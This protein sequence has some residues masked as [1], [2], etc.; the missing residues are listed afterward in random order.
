MSDLRDAFTARAIWRIAGRRG[1]KEEEAKTGRGW[2]KE[3][4]RIGRTSDL[5]VMTKKYKLQQL[6]FCYT[7]MIR[8]S[9]CKNSMHAIFSRWVSCNLLPKTPEQFAEAKFYRP[10]ASSTMAASE[11]SF[12]AFCNL[13]PCRN[14][15]SLSRTTSKPHC[16]FAG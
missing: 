8:S 7:V 6:Q 16:S 13:D 14:D 11:T 5:V 9:S 4:S 3:R 2:V 12:V 15:S 1:E 10:G